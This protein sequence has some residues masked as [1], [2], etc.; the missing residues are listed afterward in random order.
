MYM[1]TGNIILCRGG[2]K[3]ENDIMCIGMKN[4]NNNYIDKKKKSRLIM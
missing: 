2:K 1:K 4:S 3:K